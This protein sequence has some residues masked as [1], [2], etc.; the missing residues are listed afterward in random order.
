MTIKV[1]SQEV[2][3][4]ILITVSGDLDQDLAGFIAEPLQGHASTLIFD[5]A[6]IRTINS[7]GIH[8]WLGLMMELQRQ[9]TVRFRNVP[10]VLLEA[11]NIVAVFFPERSIENVLLTLECDSCGEQASFPYVRDTID[12]ADG[13]VCEACNIPYPTEIEVDHIKKY[14]L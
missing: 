14:L 8:K 3:D 7:L 11:A 5:L 9:K 13:A 1:K 10:H 6:G 4:G 2:E 12:E